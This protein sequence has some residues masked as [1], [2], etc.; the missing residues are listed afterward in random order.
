MAFVL[1]VAGMTTKNATTAGQTEVLNRPEPARGVARITRHPVNC[2]MGLWA[3]AH[4]P[5]NGDLA[6]LIFFGGFACLAWVGTWH[7]ELRRRRDFGDDWKRL[8][9]VSSVLPFVAILQ[10]RNHLA[11]KE[12]GWLRVFGGLFFFLLTLFWS[13]R[14]LIGAS[15]FPW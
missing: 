14:A 12:I 2:S 8:S 13:H 11:L 10:G 15:P 6:A 1:F 4:L 9:E 7:I 3:L 5:V